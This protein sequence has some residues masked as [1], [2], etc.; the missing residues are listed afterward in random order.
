MIVSPED[1]TI[2]LNMLQACKIEVKLLTG[3]ELVSADI[4]N[5]TLRVEAKPSL[6]GEI[7]DYRDI[8]DCLQLSGI[9]KPPN[10]TE[11]ADTVRQHTTMK[12]SLLGAKPVVAF[13]TN[14]FYTGY[15]NHLIEETKMEAFAYSK[16]SRREI[17]WRMEEKWSPEKEPAPKPYQHILYG[18]ESKKA[19]KA[20]VAYANLL[21]ARRKTVCLEAE[22]PITSGT[23]FNMDTHIIASLKKLP[24]TLD[25]LLLTSDSNLA[26]RAAGEN[27]KTAYIEQPIEAPAT[28]K[29]IQ[30]QVNMTIYSLAAYSSAVELTVEGIPTAKIYAVWPGKTAIE[31]AQEKIKLEIADENLANK[32][33]KRARTARKV[34][35]IVKEA[36]SLL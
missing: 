2:L 13:D 24:Q 31:W 32:Y 27:I 25:I 18:R 4:E 20:K 35:N 29:A 26:L 17:E 30:K 10:H 15:A 28:L 21:K 16:A 12:Q 33:R 36:S 9:L 7:V 23:S 19:R 1:I 34:K 6:Q 5:Q 8:I 22:A 11:T 3:T 14:Q